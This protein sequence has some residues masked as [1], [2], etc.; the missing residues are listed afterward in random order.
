VNHRFDI[1]NHR[2]ELLMSV[3][4]ALRE[5]YGDRFSRTLDRVAPVRVRRRHA[6]RDRVFAQRLAQTLPLPLVNPDQ[7]SM[8]YGSNLLDHIRRAASAWASSQTVRGHVQRCLHSLVTRL[9]TP[10]QLVPVQLTEIDGLG[11][12][13][14]PDHGSLTAFGNVGMRDDYSGGN[15]IGFRTDADWEKNVAWLARR[16]GADRVWSVWY[17]AW[18]DRLFL[19]N[20]DGSHHLAALHRQA[21]EQDR[22]MV[23]TCQWSEDRIDAD[24]VERL[25]T[26]ADVF[27]LHPV[28]EA[29]IREVLAAFG[30][31]APWSRAV[32]KEPHPRDVSWALRQWAILE[33]PRRAWYADALGAHIRSSGPERAFDLAAYLDACV[34][35]Q[36]SAPR[37][38]RTAEGE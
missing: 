16:F 36:T 3:P 19:S 25:R 9:R 38:N 33:V 34:A 4:R 24:V 23:F 14:E 18:T 13:R 2:R 22:T 31:A 12:A 5:F 8:L 1:P 21:R 30:I 29:E 37:S 35:R 10:Q 17:E 27:L 11:A 26:L 28:T 20:S 6:A 15:R 32:W 7:L